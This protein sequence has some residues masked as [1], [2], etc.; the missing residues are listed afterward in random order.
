VDSFG[1]PNEFPFSADEEKLYVVDSGITY[2][3]SNIR[4]FDVND[5][6]LSNDKTLAEDFAPG[7]TDGVKMAVDGKPWCG[8][9]SGLQQS[10]RGPAQAGPVRWRAAALSEADAPGLSRQR[11]R[12]R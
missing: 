4:V 10:R 6:K 9:G 12:R 7:F 2:G 3:C 11:C 5:D 8:M 1:N